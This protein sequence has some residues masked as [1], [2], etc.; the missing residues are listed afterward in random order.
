M[1]PIKSHS[2]MTPADIIAGL[3]K[4][5]RA[6]TVKNDESGDIVETRAQAERDYNTATSEKTIEAALAGESVTLIKT[7][8]AGNPTVAKLK[9][10]FEIIKGIEKAHWKQIDILMSQIDTYRSLLSWLK[11]EMQSQ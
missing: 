1:K 3:E 6:L 4:K 10:E 11:A 5:N 2:S 9:M 8:V 7:I